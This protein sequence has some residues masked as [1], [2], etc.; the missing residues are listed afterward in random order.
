MKNFLCVITFSLLS[1]YAFSQNLNRYKMHIV[2]WDNSRLTGRLESINDTAVSIKIRTGKHKG[3]VFS[4]S[5]VQTKNLKI[6]RP[7][8]ILPI[9]ILTSAGLTTLASSAANE[10]SGQ[11]IAV[12]LGV[13]LGACLGLFTGDLVST[14]IN[15][16]R[17]HKTDFKEIRSRF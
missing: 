12:V 11:I 6:W 10:G 2:T 5:A 13:P 3:E 15:K 8:Y 4:F 1:Q 9:T 16:R 17:M 7:G 14:R